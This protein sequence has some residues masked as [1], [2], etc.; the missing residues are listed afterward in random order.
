[1]TAWTRRMLA[2][3][4]LSAASGLPATA[5]DVYPTRPI[6]LVV[7][8]P[9][10]GP[11]DIVS[12]IV[13]QRLGEL[14]GQPL[15]IENRGG[16]GGEISTDIAAKGPPGGYTLPIGSLSNHTLKSLGLSYTT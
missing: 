13:G 12:R 8:F 2:V 1:M 7:P 14:L 16:A 10:A 6:R 3:V 11:T 4:L 15:V 9:A 5:Q